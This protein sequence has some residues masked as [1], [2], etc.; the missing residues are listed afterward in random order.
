MAD[1][2]ITTPRHIDEGTMHAW[3]DG[4]LSAE[5][6][7]VVES[8]VADCAACS[9]AAAEARGLI[10]ASTRILSALDDIP[11]KVIPA[12]DSAVVASVGAARS[13]P[14]RAPSM[15]SVRIYAPIAAVALFAVG[16]L[17]V[18][19]RNPALVP[20]SSQPRAPV[21]APVATQTGDKVVAPENKPAVTRGAAKSAPTVR[22]EKMPR[23]AVSETGTRVAA[24][25]PAP[26]ALDAANATNAPAA[27]RV[28]ATGSAAK[29]MTVPSTVT[30]LAALAAAASSRSRESLGVTARVADAA[31]ESAF[32]GG[33]LRRT[34]GFAVSPPTMTGARVIASNEFNSGGS[35]VRRTI[36]KLDSGATVT[37]TERRTLTARAAAD[38]AARA[39][40]AVHLT[41]LTLRGLSLQDVQS[42]M[43]ISPDGTSFT[44]AG[45]L[46]VQELEALKGRIVASGYATPRP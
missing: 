4:A 16:A 6:A 21:A 5:E 39:E 12:K 43:W 9:A 17:L 37:L 40:T 10:A 7:G 30:S 38:A 28:E 3:L 11:G 18:L 42:V 25:P 15:R 26:S 20:V 45:P 33:E 36:F 44:L 19:R 27:V 46:T 32:I 29:S 8:H 34:D 2:E 22:P 13:I 41:P 24:V 14:H 31:P 1:D 35:H 23:A